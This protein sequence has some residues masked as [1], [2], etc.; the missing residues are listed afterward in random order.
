MSAR[1]ILL[2]VAMCATIV[3]SAAPAAAQTSS[4]VATSAIASTR[5]VKDA[6]LFDVQLWPEWTTSAIIVNA[7]VTTDTPLPVRVRIPVPDGATI[8]WVG[9]ILGG[10]AE[11]DIQSPYRLV[12]EGKIVEMVLTESRM[13]QYE[14]TYTPPEMERDYL[15]AKMEW[16]QS[17]PASLVR[18]AAMVPADFK[19]VTVTPVSKYA[20]Q[21]NAAG[22]RLYVL[23]ERKMQPGDE[24]EFSVTFTAGTRPSATGGQSGV[25]TSTVVG[26]LLAAL[27][28]AIIAL[29]FVIR[30]RPSA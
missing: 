7:T 3:I 1:R 24:Y 28:A 30:R 20:P 15:V 9:E 27:A 5:L 8:D 10:T 19:D 21:F 16:V 13:A 14:A 18:F 25:S 4:S 12:D 2:V 11:E 22:E 17:V 26:G 23:D 6:P 29:L